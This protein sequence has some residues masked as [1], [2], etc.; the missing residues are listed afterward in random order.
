MCFW[1]STMTNSC[2][3]AK[4]HSSAQT[5]SGLSA[6]AG[7]IPVFAN[8]STS[9]KLYIYNNSDS[10][11]YNINYKI[12]GGNQLEPANQMIIGKQ[13]SFV[14]AHARCALNITTP[15]LSDNESQGSSSIVAT[16]SNGQKY[17]WIINYK[18]VTK[19]NN[20]IQFVETKMINAD[21]TT[22][23][24]Y[25]GSKKNQTISNIIESGLQIDTS[26]PEITSNITIESQ[27][28]IALAV[29]A[30]KNSKQ[31]ALTITSQ[32]S[33]HYSNT[34]TITMTDAIN[35][36]ILVAG[37]VP[38]VNTHGATTQTTVT[39]SNLGN[40]A[41]SGI[42]VSSAEPTVMT[43][44]DE[45]CSTSPLAAGDSCTVHLIGENVSMESRSAAYLVVNYNGAV[46]GYSP[47]NVPVYWYNT[48]LTPLLSVDAPFGLINNGQTIVVS[49]KVQ[50]ISSYDISALTENF[51][52]QQGFINIESL[53]TSC[54]NEQTNTVLADSGN[55]CTIQFK[56]TQTAALNDSIKIIISGTYDNNRNYARA[57]M[58]PILNGVVSSQSGSISTTA[59]VESSAL[60]TV[61]NNSAFNFTNVSASVVNTDNPN[62][63]ITRPN[64]P[65][66]CSG[67]G[68]SLPPGGTCTYSVYGIE[69]TVG[70]GNIYSTIYATSD[71]NDYQISA[72]TFFSTAMYAYISNFGSKTITACNVESDGSFSG[73][74]NQSGANGTTDF[75]SVQQIYMYKGY[76]YIA[77][78]DTSSVTGASQVCQATTSV[79]LS[80]CTY[81]SPQPFSN[82]SAT[83]GIVAVND[84]L[85]FSQWGNLNAVGY[86]TNDA[87]SSPWNISNYS[88]IY[89][90]TDGY[91]G[92]VGQMVYGGKGNSFNVLYIPTNLGTLFM[93]K[94]NVDGSYPSNLLSANNLCPVS[95]PRIFGSTLSSD[96]N[97]LLLSCLSADNLTA[98]IVSCPINSDGSIDNSTCPNMITPSAGWRSRLSTQGDLLYVANF[99]GTS[100]QRWQINT[101]DNSATLMGSD[102][103]GGLC[104]KPTGI[105]FR[106]GAA[107]N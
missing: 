95:A 23:Y 79:T 5:G 80:S 104:N 16:T 73:C 101:E 35:G 103:C 94:L 60:V 65:I 14:S 92:N 83:T 59:G 40:A 25:N 30:E 42:S 107:L 4:N 13:C 81:M 58:I 12:A 91:S 72:K 49:I 22:I 88:N 8:S 45:N 70:S 97:F 56:A 38:P 1:L 33:A 37:L 77:S 39:I 76:L 99:D 21:H 26:I 51:Y 55:I 18:V 11:V 82:Q 105:F 89:D 106:N 6:S 71:G 29:T 41:A 100:I 2:S 98:N 32:D 47:L 84:N 61:T 34:S 69:S 85:Y 90:S 57:L 68:N 52:S 43:I 10:P 46:S 20:G 67:A 50:N 62:I 93:A 66:A 27:Q 36:A 28:I 64:P 63:K 31:R 78:N 17:I 7:V 87:T 54:T 15:W 48:Y 75:K 96:G 3:N 102:S 86:A 9:T 74:G 53:P 19:N 24:A 44:G